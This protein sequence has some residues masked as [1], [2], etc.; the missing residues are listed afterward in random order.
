MIIYVQ[1][2]QWKVVPCSFLIMVDSLTHPIQ[3]K[4]LLPFI[5]MMMSVV[6]FS[7]LF[8]FLLFYV[9]VHFGMFMTL[10][11]GNVFDFAA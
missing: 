9:A 7:G 5:T 3:V 8:F 11:Q 10:F 2:V 4:T 6:I 1:N